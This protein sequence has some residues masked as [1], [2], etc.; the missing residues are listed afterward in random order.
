MNKKI[1]LVMRDPKTELETHMEWEGHDSLE[2]A[3]KEYTNIR[4]MSMQEG[5]KP[6]D[7]FV[8]E[9]D[10]PEYGNVAEK[11]DMAEL[12][13]HYENKV[14]DMNF[15]DPLTPQFEVINND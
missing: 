10:I 4:N 15:S 2:D 5:V 1:F 3:K 7:G 12:A 13:K 6:I 11:L 8:Y 9:A 14:M